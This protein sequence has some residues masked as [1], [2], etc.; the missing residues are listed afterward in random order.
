MGQADNLLAMRK[1]NASQV[2][3]EESNGLTSLTKLKKK[4]SLIMFWKVDGHIKKLALQAT[5][6]VETTVKT[7]WKATCINQKP[8]LIE[9]TVYYI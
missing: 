1:Q 9:V 7:A 8:G 3:A 5:V 2:T 4:K 6:I